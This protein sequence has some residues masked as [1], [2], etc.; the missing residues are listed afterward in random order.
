MG[1]DVTANT[2]LKPMPFLPIAPLPLTF[3]LPLT[4]ESERT[5]SS[6]TPT[7]LFVKTR[8]ESVN[9]IS[10]RGMIPEWY[11]LS[12]LQRHGHAKHTRISGQTWAKTV[13]TPSP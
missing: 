2:L 1:R 13:P 6:R 5:S 11:L 12:S 10:R 9:A 4:V 7:S 8:V 3:V